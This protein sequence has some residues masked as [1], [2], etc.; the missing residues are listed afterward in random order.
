MECIA[1]QGLPRVL[2]DLNPACHSD[3]ETWMV[4]AG[5][6]NGDQD[7]VSIILY[8]ADRYCLPLCVYI[9][10]LFQTLVK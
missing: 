7:F 4:K 3:M 9:E 1:A 8:C 6:S 2:A 5:N 10:I